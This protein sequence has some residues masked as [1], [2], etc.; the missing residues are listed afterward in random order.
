MIIK[1]PKPGLGFGIWEFG[2]LGFGLARLGCGNFTIV[3]QH[4]EEV[5]QDVEDLI[6]KEEIGKIKEC[7]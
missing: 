4:V 7:M 1:P 3:R 5:K 6:K 2:I